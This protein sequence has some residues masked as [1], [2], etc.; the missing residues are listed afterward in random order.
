MEATQGYVSGTVTN[1][2]GLPISPSAINV[3]AGGTS[4]SSE[5]FEWHIFCPSLRGTYDIVANQNNQNSSY[6]SQ[7]SQ[8]VVATLGQV[9]SDVNFILSQGGRVRGNATRD[10]VNAIAGVS[11]V[12]MD[13]NDM[14]RAQRISYANGQFLLINLGTRD[15]QHRAYFGIR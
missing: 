15:L 1:V 7:T 2:L 6:V 14:A 4:R 13:T 9:T 3:G 8:T 11:F 12:A 5:Y 10:G